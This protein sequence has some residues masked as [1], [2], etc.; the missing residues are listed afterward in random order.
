MAPAATTAAGGAMTGGSMAGGSMQPMGKAAPIP[1]DLMCKGPIVWV[2]MSKK[3]YHMAGD[4]YYGRTKHGQY[5]CQAGADAKGYHMAGMPRAHTGSMSG[6]STSG[7][8]GAS[9]GTTT[10]TTPAPTYT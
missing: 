8:S 5:M 9:G 6:G 4:P 10:G 1:A 7:G 3:T 2:N